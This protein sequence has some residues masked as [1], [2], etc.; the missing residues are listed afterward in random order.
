MGDKAVKASAETSAFVPIRLCAAIER[1]RRIMGWLL[2]FVFC[3]TA[4]VTAST[5]GP[6]HPV[7]ELLEELG[8]LFIAAAVAGR[9]LCMVYIGGQKNRALFQEGPYSVCRNPLYFCSIL[10]IVG[11]GMAAGSITLAIV[12]AMLFG[13]LFSAIVCSEEYR[14]AQ[15]FGGDYEDYLRRVP[16]WLPAFRLW[17]D[18]AEL[19]P[20]GALIARTIRDSAALLLAIPLFEL[21]EYGH[22]SGNLPFIVVAP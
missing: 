7:R 18:P 5:W 22:A 16:R 11:V 17:C 10:G 3:A 1:H 6:D 13:A 20:R 12:A 9:A 21:V 4:L 19:S 2:V 8:V 15:A 14:L